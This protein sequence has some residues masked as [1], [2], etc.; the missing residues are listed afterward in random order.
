MLL[1]SLVVVFGCFMMFVDY[2]II[3]RR[4][5][6]D[7]RASVQRRK[8]RSIARA[9]RV[10]NCVHSKLGRCDDF[11]IPMTTLHRHIVI[12]NLELLRS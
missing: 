2:Q 4:L 11:P 5:L 3:E 6:E 8:K 10:T 7:S 9:P 12:L 1:A